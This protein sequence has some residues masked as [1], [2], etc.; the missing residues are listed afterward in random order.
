MHHRLPVSAALTTSF[1]AAPQEP[2][3][4][5]RLFEAACASVGLNGTPALPLRPSRVFGSALVLA[6]EW[7]LVDL[8]QRLTA[9]IDASYEPT[10]D[11]GEFTFAMGLGE[12]HP[13]GQFNAFLAAGE[14]AGPGMW[15]RLSEAPLAACPQLVDVDFPEMAFTRAEWLDGNLHLRLAPRHAD[16]SRSTSFRLVGAEP[17]NWDVHGIDGATLDLTTGGVH[18]RVPMV[19]AD[20]QL[21]RG[22]Y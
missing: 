1:Y 9:A 6:R 20:V 14:A 17:R 19:H 13:R 5:R 15:T 7:G 2:D 18:V 22:S 4:A 12:P 11:A 16:R 21:I 10:W 3:D 8:E